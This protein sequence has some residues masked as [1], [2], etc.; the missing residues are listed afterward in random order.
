MWPLL[1]WTVATRRLRATV[2]AARRSA[3]SRRFGAWAASASTGSRAIPDLLRRLSDIQSERSYSLVGM[4]ATAGLG[5]TVGQALTLA[6]RRRAPRR[7]R[8][9]SRGAATRRARSRARSPRRSRLSPIVW[10]HYLVVLL[11][12]TGD[13]ATAVLGALAPAGAPVGQPAARLRGGRPD[14]H[15]GDRGRRSSSSVLLARPAQR[16]ESRLGA[17]A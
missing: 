12:P 14:L 1:V 9:S 2:W 11:V 7:L 15:A 8:A 17:V 5:G 13:R 16:S 6:R 10:L 4:A 3:S